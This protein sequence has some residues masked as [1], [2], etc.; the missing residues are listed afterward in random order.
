M[1][2]VGD[3]VTVVALDPALSDRTA[4]NYLNKTGI[5]EDAPN[6]WGL[7]TIR[8]A[9]NVEVGFAEKELAYSYKY[10]NINKVNKYLGVK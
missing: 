8:F 10:D 2:K 7:I 9:D 1:F 3:R 4:K 5:V 6:S